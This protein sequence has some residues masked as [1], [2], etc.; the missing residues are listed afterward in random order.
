MASRMSLITGIG[1][2]EG[3]ATDVPQTPPHPAKPSLVLPPQPW[4]FDTASHTRVRSHSKASDNNRDSILNFRD[5]I[6]ASFR[7]CAQLRITV[8]TLARGT[9]PAPGPRRS[10]RRPPGPLRSDRAPQG[11]TATATPAGGGLMQ[12]SAGLSTNTGAASLSKSIRPKQHDRRWLDAFA[13]HRGLKDVDGGVASARCRRRERT[14]LGCL[15][16]CAE[17]P[18]RPTPHAAALARPGQK[19]NPPRHRHRLRRSGQPPGTGQDLRVILPSAYEKDSNRRPVHTRWL[20][21]RDREYW[22]TAIGWRPR[23]ELR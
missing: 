1:T 23:L 19:T 6:Q 21:A 22:S 4:A 2:Y 7:H 12:Q 15:P 14:W 20:Q 13:E 9:P 3:L 5:A 16:A 17:R 11:P 8:A 18:P 10:L